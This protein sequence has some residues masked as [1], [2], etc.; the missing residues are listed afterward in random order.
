[1]RVSSKIKVLH[2]ITRT[3]KINIKAVKAKLSAEDFE[4]LVHLLK[5]LKD[6]GSVYHPKEVIDEYL[7]Q[8][9][10]E[11]LP[12]SFQGTRIESEVLFN[13][14]PQDEEGLTHVDLQHLLLSSW[15]KPVRVNMRLLTKHLKSLGYSVKKEATPYSMKPRTLVAL[16][17]Q[18][19]LQLPDTLKTYT[20]KVG[21]K[22]IVKETLE[23]AP[24]ITLK[25]EAYSLRP[26][27]GF[28]KATFLVRLRELF[29]MGNVS[30]LYKHPKKYGFYEDAPPILMLCDLVLRDVFKE[31]PISKWVHL[32]LDHE[33]EIGSVYSSEETPQA[34]KD[35]FLQTITDE[36]EGCLKE[37][38]I[39]GVPCTEIRGWVCVV[40]ISYVKDT[41]KQYGKDT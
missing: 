14:H 38:L 17:E 21:F 26:L 4:G 2:W 15:C 20:Q 28:W 33:E 37:T 19:D 25:G 35:L 30:H 10:I 31:A 16:K 1:M 39:E 34:Y 9:S 12:Q 29:D 7:E 40:L 18:Y 41:L 6:V 27:D 24:S 5:M 3:Y 11:Y 36:V 23:R 13:V 8:H 22:D 32:V